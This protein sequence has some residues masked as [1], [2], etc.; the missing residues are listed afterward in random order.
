MGINSDWKQT[1]GIYWRQLVFVS[2][3][4]RTKQNV[5]CRK[6]HMVSPLHNPNYMI[7][8][9]WLK[10]NESIYAK[11]YYE[12][13]TTERGEKSPGH[14]HIIATLLCSIRLTH[15][16]IK[17]HELL[18]GSVHGGRLSE[19][20]LVRE[21]VWAIV[22]RC[23]SSIYTQGAPAAREWSSHCPQSWLTLSKPRGFHLNIQSIKEEGL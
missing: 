3:G 22:C 16:Y 1:M 4:E 23:F 5:S 10:P 9:V 13:K 7:A 21:W 20:F 2:S 11:M 14:Y 18:N 12:K 8:D 17:P 6:H 19:C 15:A